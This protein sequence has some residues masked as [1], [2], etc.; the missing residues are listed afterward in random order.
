MRVSQSHAAGGTSH[1]SNAWHP[2][3]GRPRLAHG[4]TAGT[5]P[6]SCSGLGEGRGNRNICALSEP[7]ARLGHHDTGSKARGDRY[8]ATGDT[9]RSPGAPP[10]AKLARRQRGHRDNLGSPAQST[11][12]RGPCGTTCSRRA[13]RWRSPVPLR[14]NCGRSSRPMAVHAR[15]GTSCIH[16]GGVRVTCARGTLCSCRS[17]PET[18]ALCGKTRSANA[19]G[20]RQSRPG[21]L[22]RRGTLRTYRSPSRRHGDRDRWRTRHRARRCSP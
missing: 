13:S 1:S 7:L 2:G 6:T 19:W 9:W 22:P 11:P 5:L 8:R 16:P 15:H 18:H 17:M 21:P 14:D 20:C 3:P 10:P 12:D 4:G